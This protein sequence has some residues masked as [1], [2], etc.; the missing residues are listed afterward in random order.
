MHDARLYKVVRA[1]QAPKVGRAVPSTATN[2]F[3]TRAGT[4]RATFGLP[5]S[6]A[7]DED[8]SLRSLRTSTI[9]P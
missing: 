3:G 2:S 5:I 7:E 1:D 8:R 9:N 6:T 4:A